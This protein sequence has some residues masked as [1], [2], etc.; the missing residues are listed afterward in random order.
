MG[1]WGKFARGGGLIL[2]ALLCVSAQPP[3]IKVPDSQKRTYTVHGTG[4]SIQPYA[5]YTYLKFE[6]GVTV[7]GED[8][9]LSAGAVE[10][11]IN[12][13]SLT[14]VE[15]LSLPTG[16]LDREEVTRDPG[17]IAKQMSRELKLPD[18]S[19]SRSALRKLVA[20]GGVKVA[21]QGIVLN[22]P[23]LLSSD[24]GQSWSTVGRS[25][26]VKNAAPGRDSDAEH[27]SLAADNLLYDSVGQRAAARGKVVASFSQGRGR[28]IELKAEQAEVD[29]RKLQLSV[30]GG[31]TATYD[32]LML[33]C[34]KLDAD[35]GSSVLTASGSGELRPELVDSER[36]IT[37]GAGW[38]KVNL[39]S[40]AVS[41]DSGISL[42][43]S[44]YGIQLSAEELSGSLDSQQ[45]SVSGKV[46]ASES[47]HKLNMSAEKISA[48]LKA[49]SF[50]ASGKPEIR[51]GDS[52]FTGERI[53]VHE[54]DVPGETRPRIIVEVHG[55]QETRIDMENPPR[56]PE[57]K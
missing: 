23:E 57:K 40:N 46:R 7:S 55:E 4:L 1:H 28:S 52:V 10:L 33:S 50:E 29:L 35:L 49:N 36:G 6:S 47:E 27:Y 12:T 34:E 13:K 25:T 30:S 16:S 31:L 39:D 56:L 51:Q 22:T 44:S 2:L 45:F 9:T 3:D 20:S 18:A 11:E 43:G 24:G 32:K 54:E 53:S 14:N 5:D 8:F 38:I 48:D 19:F 26:L 21:T 15:G 41:A 37:L 42:R 17:E